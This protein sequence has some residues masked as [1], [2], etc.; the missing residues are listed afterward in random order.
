MHSIYNFEIRTRSITERAST[1][2]RDLQRV[3][4]EIKCLFKPNSE[5]LHKIYEELGNSYDRKVL[6]PLIKECAKTVIAQFNAQQLLSQRE[7]IS[8]QIKN[9][10]RDRLGSFY[11]LV[12]E[13]AI[14]DLSF[15]K[16]YEKAIE[17]KQ[18]SQQ[19]AER[20]KY[21][22]EQAIQKKKSSII[23]AEADVEAIKLIGTA[24]KTNPAYLDLEKIEAAKFIA[25]QLQNGNNKV[26]LDSDLLMMN[27]NLDTTRK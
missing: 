22:V 6:S 3:D 17:D 16:Q 14:S 19:K 25:K 12:D 23:K 13:I 10:L 9:S 1:C 26:L 27:F 11:I 15:S 24:I 8:S 7:M 20:M 21:I 18:I 5:H 4:F 2:N